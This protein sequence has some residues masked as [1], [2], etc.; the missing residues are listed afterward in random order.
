VI[1]V[2]RRGVRGSHLAQA[3]ATSPGTGVAIVAAAFIAF[4]LITGG[5]DEIFRK[6]KP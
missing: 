6:K 5:V 3:P 4:W 2:K 1:V